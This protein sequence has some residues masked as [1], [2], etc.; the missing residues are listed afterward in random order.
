MTFSDELKSWIETIKMS[1]ASPGHINE[2]ISV[3]DAPD[4]ESIIHDELGE[5]NQVKDAQIE[6]TVKELKRFKQG[7]VGEIQRLTSQQFGNIRS[8]AVNPVQ[9]M[10]GSVFSKLKS[11]VGVMALAAI[12]YEVVRFV[13]NELLKPGRLLDRRFRRD[14]EDEILAFR[15]RE[16]KQKL[17]AG[18]TNIIVSTIGGLRGTAAHGQVVSSRGL[19]ARGAIDAV[20][21]QSFEQPSTQQEASGQELKISFGKRR[22][23]RS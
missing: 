10:I 12:L 15:R 9:F 14:I 4:F 16:E 8:L 19:I 3:S 23:F 5:L 11:G 1:S 13:I 17:R 20:I 18:Q 7:N 22:R 2:F 21:P 6:E